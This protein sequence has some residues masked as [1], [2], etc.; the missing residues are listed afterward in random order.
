MIFIKDFSLSMFNLSFLKFSAEVFQE[1]IFY[2]YV[3]RSSFEPSYLKNYQ[4]Q[5]PVFLGRRSYIYL[6]DDNGNIIWY[7]PIWLE[8][9]RIKNTKYI[10]GIFFEFD[11]HLTE[12]KKKKFW[13]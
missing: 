7:F 13:F 10:Q 8:I 9:N 2:S 1:F 4:K 12:F 6:F 5:V 3:M 11:K